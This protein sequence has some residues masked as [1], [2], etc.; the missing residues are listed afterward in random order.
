MDNGKPDYEKARADIDDRRVG[1][2]AYGRRT[3]RFFVVV[4]VV[5]V[6]SRSTIPNVDGDDRS[7][8]P[9]T[10]RKRKCPAIERTVKISLAH[11]R[12]DFRDFEEHKDVRARARSS[13]LTAGNRD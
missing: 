1:M 6:G 2:D 12:R 7:K 4:V 3:L 13:R 10:P 11:P 5:V 8:S 9:Y